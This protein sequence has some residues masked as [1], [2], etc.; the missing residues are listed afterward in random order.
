MQET[1]LIVEDDKNILISLEFLIEQDGY[2][3]EVARTG[4]EALAKLGELKPDLVLLDVML[5]DIDGFEIARRVRDDRDLEATKIIFL[6]A[7]GRAA[8]KQKGRELGADLYVTKP[9]SP[10]DLMRQIE[11]VL[12]SR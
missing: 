10:R 4:E 1:I 5:P 12:N 3:A 8:E 11:E 6:T 7:K 2:R 9:F